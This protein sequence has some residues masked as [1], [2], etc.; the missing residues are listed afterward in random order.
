MRWCVGHRWMMGF[1]FVCH[2]THHA[3]PLAV[4]VCLQEGLP[5]VLQHHI[6]RLPADKVDVG[7]LCFTLG[8]TCVLGFTAARE[9]RR[10]RSRGSEGSATR[11]LQ[12]KQGIKAATKTKRRALLTP[13]T[14]A[15]CPPPSE[16]TPSLCRPLSAP[17][18][19]PLQPA[20]RFCAWYLACFERAGWGQGKVDENTRLFA[21]LCSSAQPFPTPLCAFAHPKS[22][23]PPPNSPCRRLLRADTLLSTTVIWRVRRKGKGGGRTVLPCVSHDDDI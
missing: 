22:G 23:P 18:P 4:V 21:S 3:A 8:L 14:P 7:A 11:Q 15:P 19:H 17:T 10:D 16:G 6:L 20:G 2:C 12:R 9:T 1:I 13:G 5:P